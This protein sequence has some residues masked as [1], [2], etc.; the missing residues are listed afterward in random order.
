MNT[1]LTFLG[2]KKLGWSLIALTVATVL[3]CCKVITGDLWID[4]LKFLTI[5]ALGAN[6]ASMAIHYFGSKNLPKPPQ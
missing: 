5:V 6:V 4:A 2:G 1:V 3:C